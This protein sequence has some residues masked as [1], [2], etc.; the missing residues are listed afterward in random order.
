MGKPISH[1]GDQTTRLV[2]KR[3]GIQWRSAIA[4]AAIA[5]WNIELKL[6]GANG[7]PGA[8]RGIT[9]ETPPKMTHDQEEK[10]RCTYLNSRLQGQEGVA[11]VAHLENAS[12]PIL[13]K[14]ANLQDLQV[15]RHTAEVEFADEDIIDN[16]GRLGGFVQ[17][18][19]QEVARAP[20]ELGIGRERRPVEVEGHVEMAFTFSRPWMGRRGAV[21]GSEGIAREGSGK[22]SK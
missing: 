17:S 13:R 18:L 15:G 2:D 14:V 21:V 11:G 20:V 19:G 5:S 16:D 1:L 12:E 3:Q 10:K 4:I 8:S 9:S 22:R 6:G 7:Y